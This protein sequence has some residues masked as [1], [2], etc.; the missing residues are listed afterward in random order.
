LYPKEILKI[1]PRGAEIESGQT[2]VFFLRTN[3][4]LLS[5]GM[6]KDRHG[7]NEYVLL[8]GDKVYV[9][10]RVEHNPDYRKETDDKLIIRAKGTALKE[11]R[12]H[13]VF[14]LADISEQEITKWF[15]KG[16]FYAWYGALC[17]IF[18]CLW[19]M[20]ISGSNLGWISQE[21]RTGLPEIIQKITPPALR[22]RVVKR[23]P[24]G[25]RTVAELLEILETQ[26]H[27]NLDDIMA[28]LHR[29]R[30]SYLAIPILIDYLQNLDSPQ[31][32][33]AKK[34]LKK[35]KALPKGFFFSQ[36]SPKTSSS[37]VY[38]K[39]MIVEVEEGM[40]LI[41]FKAR[42]L[43]SKL[44]PGEELIDSRVYLEFAGG[45]PKTTFSHMIPA[46]LG[47]ITVRDLE[48][49]PQDLPSGNYKMEVRLTVTT[50]K[51]GKPF[52]YYYNDKKYVY[53][54]VP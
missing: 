48:I 41:S 50:K 8:P 14:F 54:S 28:G 15:R 51:I 19:L 12:F 53:F 35:L 30:A 26:D 13:E 7:L 23:S 31:Q 1:D 21:Q 32:K 4:I 22:E 10:G 36:Y 5:K 42:L 6:R 47:E 2:F 29:V 34:W 20:L 3:K 24:L 39:K 25:D 40:V 27:E 43:T 49:H 45:R 16:F 33:T 17:G 38:L 9:L 37:G 52:T 46:K 18:L 44:P 11:F